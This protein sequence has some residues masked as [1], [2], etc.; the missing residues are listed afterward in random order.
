MQ[1]VSAV[2]EANY[3]LLGNQLK[4]ESHSSRMR[5]VNAMQRGVTDPTLQ[6]LGSVSKMGFTATQALA[7][8]VL[9][10]A[11]AGVL[12]GAANSKPTGSK[13][14]I[15]DGKVGA[16]QAA[17]VGAGAV[18]GTY[19]L[20]GVAGEASGKG[21]FDFI[22]TDMFSSGPTEEILASLVAIGAGAAVAYFTHG[23]GRSAR[24]NLK[25]S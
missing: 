8:P 9:M 10:A 24:H 21:F 16:K 5:R 22:S 25:L 14:S 23:I 11:V 2:N 1:P 18:V 7:S 20:T 19:L 6:P 12:V 17:F 13:K 15:K 3:H 4:G